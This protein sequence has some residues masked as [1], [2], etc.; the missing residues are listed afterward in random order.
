MLAGALLGLVLYELPGVG[1]TGRAHVA[2]LPWFGVP[3]I[4]ADVTPFGALGFALLLGPTATIPL[5]YLAAWRRGIPYAGGHALAFALLILCG[6][7]DALSASGLSASPQLLPMGFTL[8]G[9]LLAR[10]LASRFRD[11]AS[12]LDTLRADLEVQVRDRSRS[13]ADAEAGLERAEKLAAVG[14]LAAGMAHQINN[15]V[16]VLTA[17]LDYLERGLSAAVRPEDVADAV[18]ESNVAARRVGATVRQL[19]VFSRAAG[20]EGGD[21]LF[22]LE[23][24]CRSAVKEVNKH[25]GPSP[26]RVIEVEV[27]PQL[28]AWGR[29]AVVEQVLAELLRSALTA[30]AEAQSSAPVRLA[31]AVVDAAVELSVFDRGVGLV[32][33]SLAE[34]G[35][36]SYRRGKISSPGLGLAM[37]F[38]LVRALGGRI[39]ARS[40]HE[41]TRVVV[42]LAAAPR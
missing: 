12:A 9:S 3:S 41:G 4:T 11:D 33:D 6:L 21:A 30:S 15:P 19:L 14:R 16:A 18:R 35:E 24:V 5:R 36:R 31:A 10:I 27:P 34:R 37:T 25:L 8:A 2:W 40:D 38:Q 17:N 7:N 28:R 29:P 32:E 39:E 22:E 13:L 23:P 20:S 1:Q 42:R 26:A